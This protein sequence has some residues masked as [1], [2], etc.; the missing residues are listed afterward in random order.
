MEN[1]EYLV[2]EYARASAEIRYL[3]VLKNFN[4]DKYKDNRVYIDREL[5]ELEKECGSLLYKMEKEPV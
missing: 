1:Y 2:N 5:I 3:S 4:T